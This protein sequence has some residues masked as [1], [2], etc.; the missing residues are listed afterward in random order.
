[1]KYCLLKLLVSPVDPVTQRSELN[2][3]IEEC[4][5]IATVQVKYQIIKLHKPGIMGDLT[6]KDIA[7]DAIAPLFTPSSD[8]LIHQL[9][10]VCSDWTPPV[11]T[12]EQAGF[13]LISVVAH[14]VKQHIHT[15]MRESDPFFAKILDSLNYHIKKEKLVKSERLKVCYVSQFDPAKFDIEYFAYEDLLKLHSDVFTIKHIS[16]GEIIFQLAG[17]DNRPAAIPLLA[18][19]KRVKEVNLAFESPVI[20]CQ[21]TDTEY[22]VEHL[23]SEARQRVLEKLSHSYLQ[24]GKLT[25][26][27]AVLIETALNEMLTDL[28]DGGIRTGLYHYIQEQDGTI[29]PEIYKQKYHNILE[30]LLKVL[31]KELVRL[32]SVKT[33]LSE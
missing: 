3:L 6:A 19:A 22:D 28:R 4:F 29:S 24:K 13:M 8:G 2:L 5:K 17:D 21:A 16:V 1:M 27:E 30:Y 18:L 7:I 31:K 11:T 20:V 12:E 32:L 33:E 9:A 26:R 10:G 25:E 23:S 14:R 15:M